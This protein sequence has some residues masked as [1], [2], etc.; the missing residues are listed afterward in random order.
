M[1][2]LTTLT[3]WLSVVNVAFPMEQP[4]SSMCSNGC[5]KLSDWQTVLWPE[6]ESYPWQ[7]WVGL[8]RQCCGHWIVSL[9]LPLGKT[10]GH[11]HWLLYT[12]AFK[13][14]FHLFCC[15]ITHHRYLQYGLSIDC[16]QKVSS[17]LLGLWQRSALVDPYH[18]H[19]SES[20]VIDSATQRHWH[21]DSW[22]RT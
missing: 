11:W 7:P 6:P 13:N 21:W 1:A 10:V 15:C 14:Q 12:I 4:R 17:T 22:L 3:F 5:C 2:E 20:C 16:V 9:A 18:Y 19:S 8:R